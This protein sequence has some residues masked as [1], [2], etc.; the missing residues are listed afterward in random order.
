[1]LVDLV[2]GGFVC[3]VCARHDV[4]LAFHDFLFLEGNVVGAA[5]PV[6]FVVEEVLNLVANSRGAEA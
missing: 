4:F 2:W 3:V 5:V 6:L 1:M